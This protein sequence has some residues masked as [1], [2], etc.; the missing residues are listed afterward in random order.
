MRIQGKTPTVPTDAPAEHDVHPF[1]LLRPELSSLGIRFYI[2]QI[3]PEGEQMLLM[4]P[5][6]G[7]C[8]SWRP[9]AGRQPAVASKTSSKLDLSEVRVT[10]L[11]Q[12][13]DS[14][15]PAKAEVDKLLRPPA[16]HVLIKCPRSWFLDMQIMHSI[17]LA[18]FHALW[19]VKRQ[20]RSSI[21]MNCSGKT[22][23]WA[24]AA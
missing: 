24:E 17:T 18:S 16:V 11:S 23:G 21:P 3:V 14:L 22:L 10:Q 19:I 1:E 15:S 4:S 9:K 7:S 6:S 2:H 5:N 13:N 20:V 8:W 12:I